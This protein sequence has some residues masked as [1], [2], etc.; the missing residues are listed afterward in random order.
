MGERRGKCLRKP[1][2]QEQGIRGGQ[3]LGRTWGDRKKLETVQNHL[4][5]TDTWAPEAASAAP[6]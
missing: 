6:I 5:W 1:A 2:E 4:D 3:S